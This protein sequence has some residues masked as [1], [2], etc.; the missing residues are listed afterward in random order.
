MKLTV[1]SAGHYLH[2]L[3]EGGPLPDLRPA[4]KQVC[5][6]RPR[7]VDRF[8]ELAL[9]GS[10]LCVQGRELKPGCGIYLGS[11]FGPMGS[12]VAVQEQLLRDK[13]FPKPFDFMNILGASA[14]FHVAKNLGLTG[15]NLFI[16]RRGAS[17]EA[18]LAHVQ[19]DLKLGVVD[20]ALVGVVEEATLPLDQHRQ[21]QGLPTGTPVAEGSHWLLLEKE[22]DG[23]KPM[24]LLKFGDEAELGAYLHAHRA[25]SVRVQHAE[26]RS[27]TS[28]VHDNPHAAAV[29]GFLAADEAGTLLLVRR[30]AGESYTL[31]HLGA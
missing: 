17:L 6:E 20:Q 26:D 1:V 16:S 9:L 21:R 3:R 14:G 8:I 28:G 27:P 5:R 31:L 4:L 13:E 24:S 30:G 25:P 19:A 29:T 7:R 2:T 22:G 23:G 18:A 15:Q 10:G 12:N 11:G